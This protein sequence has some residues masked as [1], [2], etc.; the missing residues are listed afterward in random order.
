MTSRVNWVV[1]SSAVDYLHLML[2]AMKWLIDT[3]QIRCRFVMSKGLPLISSDF[4]VSLVSSRY[5]RWSSIHVPCRRSVRSLETDSA[6]RFNECLRYRASL[7]LQITNLL[8]RAMFASRLNM[9]DLP[10]VSILECADLYHWMSSSRWHSSAP[11]MST[12]VFERNRTWIVRHR[13]I[14]SV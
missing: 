12:D 10:A 3:N 4:L 1:Q 13:A 7:A 8:T 6:H 5:S 14:H 2:V 11:W 9:N